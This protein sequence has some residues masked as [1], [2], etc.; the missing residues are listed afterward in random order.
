MER[1]AKPLSCEMRSSTPSDGCAVHPRSASKSSSTRA[2]I[3]VG[4]A[5]DATD[6]DGS[7]PGAEAAGSTDAGAHDARAKMQSAARRPDA[8]ALPR[9]M[10]RAGSGVPLP[11]APSPLVPRGEGENSSREAEC[12]A[13]AGAPSP[14][15]PPPLRGGR[16]RTASLREG[17]DPAGAGVYTLSH[18]VCG[19]GWVRFTNL[20]EG[21]LPP[22]RSL[23]G[24]VGEGGAPPAASARFHA[25]SPRIP[26]IPSRSPPSR[27]GCSTAAGTG[28]PAS[29]AKSSAP[30]RPSS[31][32]CPARA[33]R[34]G[35]PGRR[36]ACT[37]ARRSAR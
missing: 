33:R 12:P 37:A 19:R 10:D 9:W 26:L 30:S 20:G 17:C 28:T 14:R 2:C 16:G 23:W 13:R 27:P 22:P 31:A 18:A 15:P 24:R 32:P 21:N 4:D 35:S 8:D 25:R 36:A 29:R 5:G 34:R 11:P 3:A 1:P 7:A 6:A